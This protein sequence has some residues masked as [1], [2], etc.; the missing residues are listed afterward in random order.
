[1]NSGP[2]NGRGPGLQESNL[3]TCLLC[4]VGK[5]IESQCEFGGW[6][7]RI[8]SAVTWFDGNAL[9]RSL[10]ERG[11]PVTNPAEATG[12]APEYTSMYDVTLPTSERGC[13]AGETKEA[14]R[15]GCECGGVSWLSSCVYV[16]HVRAAKGGFRMLLGHQGGDSLVTQE[17]GGPLVTKDGNG[18][19]MTKGNDDSLMAKKSNCRRGQECRHKLWGRLAFKIELHGPEQGLA[20]SVTSCICRLSSKMPRLQLWP[21]VRAASLCQGS[22]TTMMQMAWIW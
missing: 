1:M 14:R 4:L 13:G 7:V 12:D 11:V 16:A 2:R 21:Y 22:V 6:D 17:G 18:S 10:P 8:A 19:L 15:C 9:R 5:Q 20:S 3:Q